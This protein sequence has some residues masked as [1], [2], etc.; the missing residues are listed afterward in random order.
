MN[1]SMLHIGLYQRPETNLQTTHSVFLGLYLS[2]LNYER[3]RGTS[4]GQLI[5]EVEDVKVP[6]L[7]LIPPNVRIE[8]QCGQKRENSCDP[9]FPAG[10]PLRG[11][12][13]L[14]GAS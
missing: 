5:S 1:L 10:A 2:G 14:H 7:T 6:A 12:K 8:F 11:G 4:G 9:M 3:F 13:F